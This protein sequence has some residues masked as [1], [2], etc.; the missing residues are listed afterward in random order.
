MKKSII[1]L[2][3]LASILMAGASSAIA[4]DS[5]GDEEKNKKI[6]R[7]WIEEVAEK[8]NFSHLDE[9][10]HEGLTFHLPHNWKSPVSG[11]NKVEGKEM[12]KAHLKALKSRWENRATGVNLEID[13][14]IAEGDTVAVRGHRMHKDTK[15]NTQIKIKGMAF[16]KIKDG[17]IIEIHIVYEGKHLLDE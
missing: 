5:N 13:S 14:I 8:S 17:K 12:V 7:E 4:A 15:A 2:S 10:A 16:Y 6:V 11:T 9:N 1:N 3:I